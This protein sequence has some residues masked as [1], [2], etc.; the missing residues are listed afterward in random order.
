MNRADYRLYEKT[1]EVSV[2]DNRGQIVR[3]IR[4]QRHPDA[5]KVTDERIFR[6]RF[7]IYGHLTQSID[8]RLFELQQSDPSI[9][10]NVAYYTALNGEVLRIERADAGTSVTLNDS[11]GRPMLSINATGATQTYRYEEDT[12]P[13]RLLSIIEEMKGKATRI[14]E[15]LVWAGNSQVEKNHNLAGQCIRHYDTAGLTQ[16]DSISLTDTPQLMSQQLLKVDTDPDWQGD[17]ESVWKDR[18]AIDVFTTQS[19]SNATGALLIHIDAKGNIQRLA[20]DLAGMLCGS[21]LTLQGQAEQVMVKSLSYSAMGQKLQEE[22]G[23]RVIASYDYEP[24]SLRLIGSK[25]ERPSGHPAGAKVL[26]DLHYEYDPTGNVVRV[27]N[28]TEITRFWRNQQVDAVNDYTYDSLYQ[29]VSAS[30]RELANI[31]QQDYKLPTPLIPLPTDNSTYTNYTRAYSYD[32]GG[33]LTQFRHSAP[34]TTNNYTMN[35]TVSDRSNKAVL[36]TLTDNPANVTNL[37]DRAGHQLK[38]IPDQSLIWTERGEL[39][40]AIINDDLNTMERYMYNAHSQRMLKISTQKVS[41]SLQT[42]QALYLPGLELR[43][44]QSGE[45]TKEKLHV[46]TLD[47]VAQAQVRVLHWEIGQPEDIVNNQ[48]RYNYSSQTGSNNLELDYEGRII[49]YEE[50]YPYGGTA[51]WTASS[52]TEAEYKIIRYSGKERDMTGLYYYGYRYYL[53]TEGR[54]LSPDSAGTVNG[55]NDYQMTENNPVLYLD[56]DGQASKNRF[57]NIFWLSA[58]LTRRRG[59]GAASS[60]ARAK[61][62]TLT[63]MG[64]LA[65]AGIIGGIVASA[66]APL[67]GLLVAGGV[68]FLVGAVA[69]WNLDSITS[70]MAEIF[71]RFAKGKSAAVNIS[72][73]V[74]TAVATAGLLGASN[75]S[76]ALAGIAGGSFGY[77]GY[78]VGNADQG[79]GGAHGAG[80]GLGMVDIMGG[81]TTSSAMRVSTAAF[82]GLGG[83]FTGTQWSAEAGNNAALGSFIGGML[84]R[85]ADT[86]G[87]YVY[88]TLGRAFIN[89]GV[90]S[91]AHYVLGNNFIS[92]TLGRYAG[93]RLA[94]L[95][96]RSRN[97]N[98]GGP[99]EWTGSVTGAAVGGVGTALAH[100]SDP[101]FN[102]RVG[103]LG[104]ILSQGAGYV[105]DLFSR[106]GVRYFG[107]R[108]ARDALRGVTSAVSLA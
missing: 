44:T 40:Q 56:P 97:N 86:A 25:L 87:S 28:Q 82:G 4:Y 83:F 17:D 68:S 45:T 52:Q 75:E 3:E 19:T 106:W 13:G 18:L 51:L 77:L 88:Q 60:F 72:M 84:G 53:P 37:F 94:R 33:N 34:A 27:H 7:N 61:K 64:G 78:L 24:E 15:R 107:M 10:P 70:K 8:P 39:K 59:E 58:F 11:A 36:S 76:L 81:R 71:G 32:R 69:G 23:N 46:I 79:A 41:G 35:I 42:R 95:M 90:S 108:V 100:T 57:R 5:P 31:G 89:R 1:P 2:V 22:Y 85:L 102:R 66:G 91:L 12:Q 96:T 29:L 43:T 26:Q 80:T 48:I 21:W 16:T 30:G 38:I 9:K 67:V 50:F 103:Q 20:Y 47:E 14:T 49:T 62:I 105:Q 101:H 73:G 98:V 104:S 74:V 54:W 93:G 65:L 63:I 6:H 99:N 55:L 92:Q